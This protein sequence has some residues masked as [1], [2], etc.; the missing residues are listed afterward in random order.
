MEWAIHRFDNAWFW[1]L[2][3]EALKMRGVTP[4][5]VWPAPYEY[6]SMYF[7]YIFHKISIYCRYVVLYF[8]CIFHNFP[9]V[10]MYFPYLSIGFPYIFHI[11]PYFF[12]GLSMYFPYFSIGCPCIFHIF[13][14][15]FPYIVHILFNI[16]SIGFPYIF[17]IFPQGSLRFPGTIPGGEARWR[18]RCAAC[19]WRWKAWQRAP[20]EKTR[21]SQKEHGRWSWNHR[22]GWW[23]HLQENPIFDGKNR[24]FL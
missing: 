15:K 10:S 20:K 23:E 13:S 2:C 18:R 7:P 16:C 6:L 24:G 12:H 5:R 11:F 14:I 21:T 22:I 17:H 4:N 3:A 8:P 19:A 1:F 9:Y